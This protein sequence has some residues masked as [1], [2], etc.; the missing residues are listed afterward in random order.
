MYGSR[1][2]RVEIYVSAGIRVVVLIYSYVIPTVVVTLLILP[3]TRHPHLYRYTVAAT[4]FVHLQRE[5]GI[6]KKKKK[7]KK[8]IKLYPPITN[9][10]RWYIPAFYP[11]SY[12][13]SDSIASRKNKF[14]PPFHIF[15]IHFSLCMYVCM[16]G[17]M[18][19]PRCSMRGIARC[20]FLN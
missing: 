18:D 9:G 11:F 13:I 3:V 17:W 4:L 8:G 15:F 5:R 16:Y 1:P 10:S 6:T 12:S 20:L 19:V 7:K 2:T 14:I